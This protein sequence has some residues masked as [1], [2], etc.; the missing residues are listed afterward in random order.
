MAR[1]AFELAGRALMRHGAPSIPDF[2]SSRDITLMGQ[3]PKITEHE[4]SIHIGEIE[5]LIRENKEFTWV[6]INS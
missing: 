1:I 4:V 3:N 5:D 6:N 2:N